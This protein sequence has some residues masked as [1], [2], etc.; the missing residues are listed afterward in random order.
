MLF[1]CILQYFWFYKIVMI[2][3]RGGETKKDKKD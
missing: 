3:I 2:A 1:I